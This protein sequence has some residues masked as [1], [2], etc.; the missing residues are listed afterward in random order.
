MINNR[1]RLMRE[2]PLKKMVRLLREAEKKPELERGEDSLDDQ[3]DKYLISYESEA[4]KAKTEGLDFRMMTRRFLLEAEE[5]EE[6]EKDEA[7]KE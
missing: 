4:Q 1:R 3:I 2:S 7:G 5:D 6:G